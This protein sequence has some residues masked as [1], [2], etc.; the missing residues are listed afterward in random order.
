MRISDCFT[1]LSSTHLG[2]LHLHDRRKYHSISEEIL[3]SRSHV[4]ELL[5][6]PLPFVL[7]LL[8]VL[9]PVAH[10]DRPLVAGVLEVGVVPGGVRVQRDRERGIGLTA[11]MAGIIFFCDRN[12]SEP[13]IPSLKE[14]EGETPEHH[15]V[16]GPCAFRFLRGDCAGQR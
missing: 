9:P 14:G 2:Q 7:H 4:L 15:E 5:R 6:L 1:R 3:D 13:N 12:N 11:G 8:R 10:P 16:L